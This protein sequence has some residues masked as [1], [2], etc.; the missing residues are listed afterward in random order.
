MIKT[1]STTIDLGSPAPVF[2]LPNTNPEY[3]GD[4]VCLADF[5]GNAALL[6]IFMCNHCPYVIHIAP[7]LAELVRAYQPRGLGVAGISV[8]DVTMHGDDSPENM[9]RMGAQYR[10]TF[11]YLYDESQQ[12]AQDYGAVCTPDLYLYDQHR[13]LAYH[14]QFDGSRPGDDQP[15]TGA[16][17]TAAIDSILNHTPMPAPQLP[18]VGCSIKWKP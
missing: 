2:N 14:G 8:N 18:S 6:V 17:L 9:T 1:P 12:S 3:G 5:E 10:Y 16:D 13:E 11:P 4:T 7:R 15:V